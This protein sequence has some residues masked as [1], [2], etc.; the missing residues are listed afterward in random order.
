QF[1][2]H[3]AWAPSTGMVRATYRAE[4]ERYESKGD[5]FQCKLIELVAASGLQSDSEL[6]R[7]MI[8]NLIGQHVLVP[9]EGVEGMIL[10]LKMTTLTGGLKRP[11]F[12]NA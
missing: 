5:R 11:Y 4:I 2:L 6:T 10:R 12:F 1:D 3:L 8:S 9:R 7:A